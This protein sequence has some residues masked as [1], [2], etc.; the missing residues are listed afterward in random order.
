M[1]ANSVVIIVVAFAISNFKFGFVE[2]DSYRFNSG[3]TM[4]STGGDLSPE[5]SNEINVRNKP[6]PSTDTRHAEPIAEECQNLF[7]NTEGWETSVRESLDETV[8]EIKSKEDD[9]KLKFGKVLGIRNALVAK[10][11]ELKSR[12][13]VIK[14]NS[15][16]LLLLLD[17]FFLLH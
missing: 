2:L 11:D 17:I 9:I 15:L 3:I 4:K 10:E 7:A 14:G 1:L 8:Q 5:E 12:V 16:Q 13:E 6:K